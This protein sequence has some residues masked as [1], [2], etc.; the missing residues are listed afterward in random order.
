MTYHTGVETYLHI[1][2]GFYYDIIDTTMDNLISAKYRYIIAT[3]TTTLWDTTYQRRA[4]TKRL[5]SYGITK[6]EKNKLWY[7]FRIT[8]DSVK[9]FLIVVKSHSFK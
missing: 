9:L 8:C 6:L 7:Y 3:V 5:I 4:S 2:I 1:N